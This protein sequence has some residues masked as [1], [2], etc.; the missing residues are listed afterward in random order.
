[1]Q[2]N[3]TPDDAATVMAFDFGTQRIGVAVGNTITR[4]A[5]PLTTIELADEAGGRCDRR[6]ILVRS[7]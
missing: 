1:M 6:P 5:T 4:A 3:T 7:H 2:T